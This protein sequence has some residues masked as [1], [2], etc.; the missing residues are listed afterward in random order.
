MCSKQSGVTWLSGL[1]AKLSVKNVLIFYLHV[2][3]RGEA[4]FWHLLKYGLIFQHSYCYVRE[5][6]SM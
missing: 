5:L 1:L 3:L 2:K 4:V 6:Q